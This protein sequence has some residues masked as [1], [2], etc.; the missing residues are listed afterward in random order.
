MSKWGSQ[1]PYVNFKLI[2]CICSFAFLKSSVVVPTFISVALGFAGHAVT[3]RTKEQER[4]RKILLHLTN[5]ITSL[6]SKYQKYCSKQDRV[7][8][9]LKLQWKN[10]VQEMGNT[11]KAF[12]QKTTE[13]KVIITRKEG[14]VSGEYKRFLS[15]FLGTPERR[16][17]KWEK[18]V[19]PRRVPREEHFLTVQTKQD[20]NP[21]D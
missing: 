21:C 20:P 14:R 6:K 8:A 12:Y 13:Q 3:G 9:L 11:V 5:H 19:F 10:S 17:R 2:L 15:H 1:K 16:K 7:Q 4:L 18:W